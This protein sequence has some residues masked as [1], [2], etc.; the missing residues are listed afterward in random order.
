MKELNEFSDLTEVINKVNEIAQLLNIKCLGCEQKKKV[1]TVKE[2][3]DILGYNV[4]G[5]YRF[6]EDGKLK[7]LKFREEGGYRILWSDLQEFIEQH[8]YKE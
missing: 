4:V 5:I 3:A 2:T 7:S 6:I 1:L 8:R